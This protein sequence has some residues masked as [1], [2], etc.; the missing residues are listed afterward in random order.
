MKTKTL[1][2]ALI[3]TALLSACTE[4]KVIKITTLKEL[5][6]Y[7]AL[8]SQRIRL[9]PGTYRLTDFLCE[10]SI[11]LRLE[12]KQHPYIDFSG[13]HNTFDLQGVTLE[14]D[15]RLRKQLRHPIHTNELVVTGNNNTLTGLMIVHTGHE[16]SPG[17][18]TFCVEGEGN[19]VSAFTLHVQGSFPYGYGDLFGK[20]GPDVIR[21][22][23][24]SGFLITG[25]H[26]TVRNTKL[27]MRS[28]GHGFYVQKSASNILFE[29]CLV[30]GELRT[31]NDILK[32][33]EGPAVDVNFRTWTPNREGNYVVTPGYVKSLCEEGFRTYNRD[34]RNIT[35]RN[36]TA[37]NTRGGFELRTNGGVLLEN[38]TTVGTERAYWVGNDAVLKNCKGDAAHGP[39][40]FLEGSNVQAEL[41]VDPAEDDCLVHSLVTIQGSNNKLTLRTEGT[42]RNTALPIL[43]GYTHPEHGESM[44]PYGQAPCVGLQLVNE[45]SMPI[46]IG[47]QTEGYT[48][49]TRG[50]VTVNEGKNNT[51]ETF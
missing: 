6:H 41:V 24:H 29:N 14:I 13:S 11:K 5:A 3:A 27:F 17:G 42:E 48:L 2:A 37:I 50:E 46:V 35:F 22:Q 25:H 26:T 45:T 19:T 9:A 21:H 36:C 18:A 15:T 7:A 40:L 4:G 1:V 20:G 34:N 16:T 33:T 38:C 12:R 10:D 51:I 44:S 47:A 8:D 28:F 32:E 31:T 30:E 43:I 39:L 49:K 23:K